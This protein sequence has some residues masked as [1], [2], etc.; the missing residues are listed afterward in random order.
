MIAAVATPC[1]PQS[2]AW[3]GTWKLNAAK[4]HTGPSF[5]LTITPQGEY[6][7]ISGSYNYNFFCDS[8]YYPIVGQNL[9]ACLK[10]T[11]KVLDAAFKVDG[12]PSGTIHRE[13]SADG[14]TQTATSI[15]I[16][17]D[18]FKETTKTVYARVSGTT[19]FAGA[20]KAISS[21]DTKPEIMV[22]TLTGSILRIAFPGAK[23]Y[24]DI[25]LDG[26]DAPTQTGV[27]GARFTLSAKPESSLKLLTTKKR[28][29][30][31]V[32]Q[33]VLI[34]SPDGQSL[35]EQY[36]APDH[37]TAKATKVYDRQ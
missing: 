1:F 26:T 28:D 9:I 10:A 32:N 16:R 30:V 7:M 18:G 36:W 2:N 35:I 25:N 27:A 34:M 14:R 5:S 31:T 8:K 37:P 24:T 15:K 17:P 6:Q 13:L 12:K 22:T 29:G 11:D 33:G 19:G 4:T 20:W 21:S 3:N 23:Q